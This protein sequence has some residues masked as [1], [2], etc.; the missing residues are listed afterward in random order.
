MLC[1][2]IDPKAISQDFLRLR[3]GALADGVKRLKRFFRIFEAHMAK[4][5][6]QIPVDALR[7]P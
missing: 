3:A 2:G 4:G 7:L 1:V 5:F 6:A